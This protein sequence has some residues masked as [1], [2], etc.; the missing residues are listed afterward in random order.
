MSAVPIPADDP[1]GHVLGELLP[2]PAYL[3]PEE[4]AG[5]WRRLFPD[6]EQTL[7]PPY[8]IY[9]RDEQRILSWG[10]PV[11]LSDGVE[12][13]RQ[14]LDRL[15]ALETRAR[16]PTDRRPLE[17]DTVMAQ[18]RRYQRGVASVIENAL[19]N[20]YG[21][22]LVEVFLLFHSADTARGLGQVGRL[23]QLSDTV[24]DRARTDE[25]RQSVAAVVADLIQRS[26]VAALDGVKR[27]VE[28]PLVPRLP[29]L[30]AMV[31]HDQL[32]L[33][34]TRAPS[35][36]RLLDGYIRSHHRV[37]PAML[38]AA[39]EHGARRLRELVGRQPALAELLW[40]ACGSR[41]ALDGPHAVLQPAL[42]EALRG[43]GL[44]DRLELSAAHVELLADLGRRL[45]AL[46]LV[47]TLRR[48]VLTMTRQ[49]GH[50][51]LSGASSAT[52]IADSTRPFDYASPGIVDSTVRRF[53]LVYDLSNFTALLETVR[54]GGRRAEEQAL[55]FMYVLHGGLEEIR[56][57]R[58]L[59]FEKFLGDGA[60]YSSRRASR[61]LAAACEIQRAYHELRR[62]GFPF[63]RGIRMAMNFGA[64]SLLPMLDHSRGR[65]HFEFFGHGVVE[66]VRLTTGKS[67][68]E[69]QQIAEFLIHA[70]YAPADVDGFLAPLLEARAGGD[71]GD[72][73]EYAATIDGRGELVNEGIVMTLPFLAEL[74]RERAGEAVALVRRDGLAWAL[75]PLEPGRPDGLAAGLRLLGLARLKG[76][77]PLEL[78]EVGVWD[79]IP[80]DAVR[81]GPA[82]SLAALLRR[83]AANG[84]DHDGA[85]APDSVDER[86][87]VMTYLEPGGA[88]RW[89][90][91]EYRASDDVLVHSLEVPIRAPDFSDEE[92]LELWVLRNR[93]DLAG[94]YES[95]R[96]ETSGTTV[97]LEA[98][99]M[100]EEFAACFVAAPHRAPG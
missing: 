35:E 4:V 21:R 50:L 61:V 39:A 94:L 62:R 25:L 20:D 77:E 16:L 31:C 6:L 95:L 76:L 52:P 72:R 24:A 97:P 49:D 63:D 23:V 70:G 86:L 27:L 19:V 14:E 57:R 28:S 47:S 43:A 12:R 68:R 3:T 56:R 90:F 46:E 67:T 91:G 59:N 65:V 40:Q 7:P 87:V 29:P 88:R 79:T 9:G 45:K 11:L 71:A 36:L 82:G 100:R 38:A 15:I 2:Q 80:A 34:E 1:F 42:L 73:R 5:G 78:V 54:K 55:R 51:V 66:L 74:E 98:I 41:V 83:L 33:A 48:R 53:G 92:P 22:G 85:P 60:F 93:F 75:L 10:Y 69:V 84:A 30:L 81:E 58:R 32:L 44:L 26:A 18:R 8:P 64:Y 96:R 17:R 89:I 13:L 37:D 99:R